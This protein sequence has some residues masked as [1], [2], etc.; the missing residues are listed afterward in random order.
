MATA[1]YDDDVPTS[2]GSDPKLF[3]GAY[4]TT[5]DQAAWIDKSSHGCSYSRLVRRAFPRMRISR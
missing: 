3:L 5:R 1:V 4:H 2:R